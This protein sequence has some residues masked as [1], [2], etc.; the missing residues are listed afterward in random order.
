[1][2]APKR[3]VMCLELRTATHGYAPETVH[4]VRPFLPLGLNDG[5][6]PLYNGDTKWQTTFEAAYGDGFQPRRIRSSQMEQCPI[7]MIDRD[8]N[9]ACPFCPPFLWCQQFLNPRLMIYAQPQW[10]IYPPGNAETYQSGFVS[11]KE[12]DPTSGGSMQD[13]TPN[14]VG[15]Y[16]PPCTVTA[17]LP[18]ADA[19]LWRRG[20]I[21]DAS[22]LF[23][24][25][26]SEGFEQTIRAN[27]RHSLFVS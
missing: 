17:S 21:T 14:I 27:K 15:S 6:M 20:I 2:S 12:A 23:M 26:H 10:L 16:A 4:P 19:A 18:C 8:F 25:I 3:T 24:M 22:W 11:P 1:M 5:S 13:C 9:K 7:T